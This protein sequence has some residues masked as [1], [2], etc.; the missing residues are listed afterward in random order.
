MGREREREAGR[1][2]QT[3]GGKRRGCREERK[4]VIKNIE[5]NRREKKRQ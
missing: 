5:E 2:A 3:E 1:E 4:Y